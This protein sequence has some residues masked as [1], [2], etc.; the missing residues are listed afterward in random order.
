MQ[1][2]H[3]GRRRPT[4]RHASAS[5]TT[6]TA[7]ADGLRGGI[8]RYYGN[9]LL[10]IPMNEVRNRNKQ[11]TLTVLNPVYGNPLQGPRRRIRGPPTS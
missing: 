11:V 7:T 2:G 1:S 8:G 4:S 10:N 9:I 5:R 3:V 6:C